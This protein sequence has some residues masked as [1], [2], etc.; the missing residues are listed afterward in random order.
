MDD[1]LLNIN[2][3]KSWKDYRTIQAWKDVNKTPW[4]EGLLGNNQTIT[5]QEFSENPIISS[6]QKF[7][8]G[9]LGTTLGTGEQAFNYLMS[10]AMTPFAFAGDTAEGIHE[11]LPDTWANKLSEIMYRSPE[12]DSDDF[13]DAFEGHILEGIM[14]FPTLA[15]FRPIAL[16]YKNKGQKLPKEVIEQVLEKFESKPNKYSQELYL[17]YN[18]KINNPKQLVN[19]KVD[20]SESYLKEIADFYEGAKH[21]P[22]HPKIQASYNSLIEETLAQY[23]HMIEGGIIPEIYYPSKGKPEPYL[24]SAHMMNDVA[25]NKNLKFLKTN[26]DDLP[27]D[28]PMAKPSG[29]F[30]NGE[31]LLVNDVFRIVH[32]YYGHTP[33][34]FQFGPKGEYNAFRSHA[35]MYSDQSISALANETLF[36][37]AWVNYNK[38]IQR[39]DGSIPK[40]N[41]PDFI[42]QNERPFA[43]QKVILFDESLLN[44]DPNF[45]N[46]NASI[47]Y[48][49]D[50]VEK[51]FEGYNISDKTS[52]GIIYEY[53]WYT[54]GKK[55]EGDKGNLWYG[56]KVNPKE[57]SKFEA[58]IKEKIIKRE[59]KISEGETWAEQSKIKA[60]LDTQDLKDLNKVRI[61]QGLSPIKDTVTTKLDG[62][63][64]EAK[65]ISGKINGVEVG[66][67]NHEIKRLAYILSDSIKSSHRRFQE[68]QYTMGL[69]EEYPATTLALREKIKK[70][71]NKIKNNEVA[72]IVELDQLDELN[73]L[74]AIASQ[75]NKKVLAMRQDSSTNPPYSIGEAN[76]LSHEVGHLIHQ[77]L[78]KNTVPTFIEGHNLEIGIANAEL[79]KVSKKMRPN[80]WD[81]SF[82]KE[83][84]VTHPQHSKV[85]NKLLQEQITYRMKDVEL[86]ADFIKGYLT[87]PKL[88]KELA[89]N[90]SKILR[91]M[92]NESWFADILKLAKADIM[93]KDGLL[94]KQEINSGLLN[95][96]TV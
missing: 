46:I 13:G 94:K 28:H 93:P 32:D 29:I 95:T 84:L 88:T 74:K 40:V 44:K 47:G 59:I 31:E 80:L 23:Q 42:P 20:V 43:D 79:I 27:P 5:G 61:E 60:R 9:L 54:K 78:T 96:A 36:Q 11:A 90:M 48:K 63:N 69:V 25:N 92:V 53:D 65:F 83:K 68:S 2:N 39:K 34:G 73:N 24:S 8:K 3:D 51:M 41:D 76:T 38:S 55:W 12:M 1:N 58:K 21:Q 70:L 57:Q 14:A 56:I 17:S 35:N 37:N 26:L 22:N 6:I 62:K 75:E 91:D 89:P 86:L 64:I 33:N 81:D 18:N 85:T 7:N 19:N 72:G 87:D 49:M 66:L 77:Q 50:D 45:E 10:G 82:Y 71:E 30:I 67:E 15:E 52:Q 4:T 16:K